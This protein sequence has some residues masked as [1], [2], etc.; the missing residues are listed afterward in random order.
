MKFIRE[1]TDDLYKKDLEVK[2]ILE[3]YKIINSE[4]FINKLTF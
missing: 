3:K 1:K 4:V 2:K